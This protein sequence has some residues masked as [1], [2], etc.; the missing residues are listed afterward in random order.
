[1][2]SSVAKGSAPFG[3]GAIIIALPLFNALM[4]LFT[5]VAKGFVE[6]TMAAITPF[7]RK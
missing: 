4:I 7:G 5:G 1:M 2:V 3:E 6:G